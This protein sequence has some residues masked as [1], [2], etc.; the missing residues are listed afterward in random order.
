MDVIRQ[1]QKDEN[2]LNELVYE[3]YELQE[4]EIK[5]IKDYLAELNIK[6]NTNLITPHVE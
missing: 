4:P 1:I 2:I 6:A 5:L 3:L